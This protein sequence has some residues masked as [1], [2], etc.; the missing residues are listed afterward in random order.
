MLSL[1]KTRTF[2]AAVGRGVLEVVVEGSLNTGVG[3]ACEAF[4]DVLTVVMYII[5]VY[6]PG[7]VNSEG[8]C[9][10]VLSV[11]NI[12]TWRRW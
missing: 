1:V 11:G 2:V 12:R 8:S 7:L 10:A 5:E 6:A 4:V 3:D 9:D